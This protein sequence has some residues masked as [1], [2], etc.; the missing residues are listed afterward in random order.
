MARLTL[1][2]IVLLTTLN[3]FAQYDQMAGVFVPP[4]EE[5]EIHLYFRL[6]RSQ[7]LI[8]EDNVRFNNIRL[9]IEYNKK[10]RMGLL[11]SAMVDSVIIQE[12]LPEDAT[13]NDVDFLAVGGFFEFMVINNYRWELSVPIQA[14][15][16]FANY[17]YLDQNKDALREEQG[18]YYFLTEVG[19]S[20]Q[21]NVN[22]WFGIG[23]G[24]GVRS[25]SA[26]DETLSDFSKG[27]YYNFGARFNIGG[28]Y[29]SIFK[30]QEVI[31]MKERYFEARMKRRSA[32]K[33]K[34]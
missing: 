26:G 34:K 14:G 6:S 7:S 28:L 32:K 16:G 15:Y 24:L 21:Y 27:P 4:L 19:I 20:A 31:A 1:F 12:D 22:N 13:Y 25:V 2:I 3:S 8:D 11:I 5:P 10:Y 18:P 9:G 23:G 30:K 17:K 29:Q 33:K